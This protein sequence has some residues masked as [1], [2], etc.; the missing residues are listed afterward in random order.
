MFHLEM[1]VPKVSS[2]PARRATT[3]AA[4]TPTMAQR[5]LYFFEYVH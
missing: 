2:D 4:M 5:E 3:P 1:T